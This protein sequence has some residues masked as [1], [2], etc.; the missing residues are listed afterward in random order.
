[1]TVYATPES[2]LE[3]FPE[4]DIGQ[5]S[6]ISDPGMDGVNSTRLE[7]VCDRAN[8]WITG[9]LE[10]R[11]GADAVYSAVDSDLF[12]ET[13]EYFVLVE[14]TKPDNESFEYLEWVYRRAWFDEYT[15]AENPTDQPVDSSSVT[16]RI[17]FQV[18]P[19]SQCCTP[20]YRGWR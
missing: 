8:A 7:K 20:R 18:P 9:K 19:P 15:K 2:V 11:F 10:Q 13:A 6:F 17:A 12:K 5:G 1:M 3:R 14:L 16:H 4:A